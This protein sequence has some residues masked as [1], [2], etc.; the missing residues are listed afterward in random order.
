MKTRSFLGIPGLF[1]MVSISFLFGCSSCQKLDP[2]M[3]TQASGRPI[4]SNVE[5][6]FH[7]YAE[8]PEGHSSERTPYFY[9]EEG[10]RF[11]IPDNEAEEAF[12]G[13]VL[14]EN[15]HELVEIGLA[16]DFEYL[17]AFLSDLAEEHFGTTSWKVRSY[18]GAY[19]DQ[20]L[21]LACEF[22][23]D[24]G[25]TDWIVVSI[26]EVG[27]RVPTGTIE[28]C[29]A[30]ANDNCAQEGGACAVMAFNG[31]TYLLCT[32]KKDGTSIGSKGC[33]WNG[34]ETH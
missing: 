9:L 25:V 6:R 10:M 8:W 3:S 23:L 21:V 28:E 15:W 11:Q 31:E 32:C 24:P 19:G 30:A 1:A 14:S 20:K 16:S 12:I 4:V 27:R 34:G 29:S 13:S 7:F 2:G 17:T 18:Y 33:D 5:S 22:V 26:P